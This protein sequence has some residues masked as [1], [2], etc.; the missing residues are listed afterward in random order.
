[1]A[2][3]QQSSAVQAERILRGPCLITKFPF[4][5]RCRMGG[6]VVMVKGKVLLVDERSHGRVPISRKYC[7]TVS[8]T[9]AEHFGQ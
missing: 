5:A 9:F 8:R 6:S 1:V 2:G 3:D 4:P 7:R